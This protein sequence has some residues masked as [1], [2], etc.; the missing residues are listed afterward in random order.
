[1]PLKVLTFSANR[2]DE[3]QCAIS[4]WR[5]SGGVSLATAVVPERLSHAHLAC[6]WPSVGLYSYVA[7]AVVYTAF[8]RSR[9]LVAGTDPGLALLL[10]G[11]IGAGA[12]ADPL[13]AAGLVALSSIIAGICALGAW[14]LRWRLPTSR[15]R[16]AF[17]GFSFGG[18]VVIVGRQ[19]CD[20]FL[21]T[22]PLGYSLLE[23]GQAIS[24]FHVEVR[25]AN[26]LVGGVALVFLLVGQRLVAARPVPAFLLLAGLLVGRLVDLPAHGIPVMVGSAHPAA[27]GTWLLLPA[28]TRWPELVALGLSVF[29]LSY[30]EDVVSA[31][32]TASPR[33]SVEPPGR[34]LLIN[35]ITNVTAGIVGGMPVAAGLPRTSVRAKEGP[36][37]TGMVVS[38]FLILLIAWTPSAVWALPAAV[39]DA[40]LI[41]HALTIVGTGPWQRLARHERIA[42]LI[43]L[44]T[45]LALG[46][47]PGLL[48]GVAASLVA[49]YRRPRDR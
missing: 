18:A 42:A 12:R 39:L 27:V 31:E 19:A 37:P 32:E 13:S 40:N 24:R 9:R 34:T 16:G 22:E 14:A 6:L 43:T 15:C 36:T 45:V 29:L 30:A 10:G 21:P 26:V 11:T 47:L 28:L 41:C 48:A 5:P 23:V 49:G 44:A 38:V 17:V 2:V 35:G 7:S 33:H 46:P 1:V 20:I 3:R 8:G 25:G 4:K